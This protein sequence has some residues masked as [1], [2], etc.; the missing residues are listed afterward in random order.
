MRIELAILPDALRGPEGQ[1][2]QGKVPVRARYLR[3]DAAEALLALEEAC[4]GLTYTDIYRSAEAQLHARR[5]KRGVQAVGYSGHGYGLS[6]D[7]DLSSTLR[8]LNLRYADLTE[9]LAKYGWF[10]HRRDLDGTG[11][12]AWHFN[13]FG[14]RNPD[15]YLAM[16]KRGDRNSWAQPLETRILEL[17]GTEFQLSLRELQQHLS[18]LRFYRGAIDGIIGPIST[19]AIMAF[20]RA[21]DVTGDLKAMMRALA[22]VSATIISAPLKPSVA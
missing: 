16:A 21:W 11:S 20:R 13:F 14:T 18:D 4:G 22:F 10:C 8:R 9:L 6:V 17:H 7:V 3:Q 5:I 12:E 2:Y 19:E 1:D 15:L